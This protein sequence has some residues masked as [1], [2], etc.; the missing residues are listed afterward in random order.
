MLFL[1]ALYGILYV[2]LMI[3]FVISEMFN[4][5]IPDDTPAGIVYGAEFITIIIMGIAGFIIREVYLEHKY[6]LIE[7]DEKHGH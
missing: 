5:T 7:R 4:I 1:L 2:F 3:P 6:D